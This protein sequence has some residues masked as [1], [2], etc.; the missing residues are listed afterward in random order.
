MEIRKISESGCRLVELEIEKNGYMD[1]MLKSDGEYSACFSVNDE[2]LEL[3]EDVI[4]EY[5]MRKDVAK[6]VKP[7]DCEDKYTAS[8]LSE[9]GVGYNNC[10]LH[11]IPNSVVLRIGPCTVKVPQR[12]FKRFSEW[13]LRDQREDKK[14]GQ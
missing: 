7:C 10:F 13:Y 1:M 9:Q 8:K 12:I 6:K 3:I 11:L 4:S 2:Y 5:F 14:N